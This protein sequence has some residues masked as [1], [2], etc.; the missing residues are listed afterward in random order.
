M[1]I[2]GAKQIEA[3]PYERN[4]NCYPFVTLGGITQYKTLYDDN[5]RIR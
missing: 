1:V 3:G 4:D 5:G 2:L